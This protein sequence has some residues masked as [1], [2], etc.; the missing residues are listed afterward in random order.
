MANE[1]RVHT[2]VPIETKLTEL[3]SPQNGRQSV[4]G[5]GKDVSIGGMC[6]LCAV[7]FTQGQ[8][9]TMQFPLPDTPDTGETLRCEG[10]VRWIVRDSLAY[11]IGVQFLNLKSTDKKIIESIIKQQRSGD[12]LW[13]RLLSR[14]KPARKVKSS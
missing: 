11:L 2:R 12:S 6:I 5:I 1:R 3:Y 9:V 13:V 7:A 10:E 14:L 8:K 4:Q